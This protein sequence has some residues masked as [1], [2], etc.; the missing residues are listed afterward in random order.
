MPAD[1]LQEVLQ[2]IFEVVCNW[3][4]R[5]ALFVLS[6]GCVRADVG[7]TDPEKLRFPWYGITRDPD[8]LLVMSG[9]ATTILGLLI[10]IATIVT[11][12]LVAT[13]A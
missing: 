6:F 12:A 13:H 8:G 2:P 7:P 1:L 10:L 4:G 3:T 5:I 11:I 9:D